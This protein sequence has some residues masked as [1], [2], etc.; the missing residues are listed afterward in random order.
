MLETW[1]LKQVLISALHGERDPL[2]QR[3]MQP[4]LFTPPQVL[5]AHLSA[6]AATSAGAHCHERQYAAQSWF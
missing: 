4:D 6:A 3:R 1:C 2:P 5:V